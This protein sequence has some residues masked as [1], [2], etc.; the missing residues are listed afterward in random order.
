VIKSQQEKIARGQEKGGFRNSFEVMQQLQT[1]G[2]TFIMVNAE[3]EYNQ[4]VAKTMEDN[5]AQ[6]AQENQLLKDT[7]QHTHQELQTVLDLKCDILRRRRGYDSE[8]DSAF[9]LAP[10][11]PHLLN[12]PPAFTKHPLSTLQHNVARFKEA[13][14]AGQAVD[15]RDADQKVA[16]VSNVKSLIRNYKHVIESQEQLLNRVILKAKEFKSSEMQAI[17][18]RHAKV[19]D[20][21]EVERARRFIEEQSAYLE[22]KNR[23]LELTRKA[24]QTTVRRVEQEREEFAR[25]S[26]QAGEELQRIKRQVEQLPAMVEQELAGF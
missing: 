23:E 21:E 26:G 4:M 20:E 9:E 10:L 19:M 18:G 8:L 6:I 3:H 15:E 11:R 13:M 2:P 16:C 17:E 5:Y 22:G 25:R 24:M 1:Y 14:R 12:L 7:L